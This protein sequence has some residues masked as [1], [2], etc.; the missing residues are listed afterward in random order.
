MKQPSAPLLYPNLS[1]K[2]IDEY[3]EDGQNYRLQKISEIEKTLLRESEI[4][5]SLY[6]KY[7]RGINFTDSIDTTLI[8][9]SVILATVGIAIPV[10]L[11]VQ[12]TAAICG[13]V[14]VCIKLIRRRLTTKANKHY[15]IKTIADSK[16]NSIKD[17]ISKSLTD[18]QINE[19][20]FKLILDE[21]EKYNIL[22]EN[23]LLKN[24]TKPLN[25]DEIKKII[26]ETEN[27][28]RNEIK[29]KIEN[30]SL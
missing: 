21:L 4:R 23:I 15:K 10:L 27:R 2:E 7:K 17:L 6:K 22:K 18:G 1:L 5:K 20:E 11:P 14:G 25:D 28:V 3:P 9:T 26:E 30:G 24:K 19:S 13:S 16:L 29:K 8:S 12:I